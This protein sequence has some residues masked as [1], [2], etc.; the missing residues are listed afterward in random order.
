MN[1]R[2]PK[3]QTVFRVNPERIPATGARARCA[4]CGATFM[5]KRPA[6]APPARPAPAPPPPPAPPPV[7]P[8]PAPRASPAAAPKATAPAGKGNGAAGAAASTP[9]RAAPGRGSP[10][11]NRD[12]DARAERLARALVSD[13]VAYNPDRR[14]RSLAE[15]TLR[16]EFRD[17]ILKSWEEYVAQV[18]DSVARSTPF[19]RDALNKILAQGQEVF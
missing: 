5:V 18:G 2:C 11:G 9:P 16:T 10:L 8:R 19:F 17:E 4:R 14:D 12:P 1:I 3:C 7:A 15:G 6:A 13:I